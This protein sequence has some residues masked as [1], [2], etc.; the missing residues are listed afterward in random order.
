MDLFIKIRRSDSSELE[1]DAN[2]RIR[3]VNPGNKKIKSKKTSLKDIKW[4]NLIKIIRQFMVF[5]YPRRSIAYPEHSDNG[6][7]KLNIRIHEK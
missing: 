1:S 4:D 5:S 3:R 7:R 2:P 6:R